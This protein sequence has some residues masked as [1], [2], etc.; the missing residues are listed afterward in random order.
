MISLYGLLQP[1]LAARL[2][3]IMSYLNLDVMCI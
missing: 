2:Y 3:S 1:V